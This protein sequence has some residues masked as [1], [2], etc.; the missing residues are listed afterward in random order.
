AGPAGTSTVETIDLANMM[1]PAAVI[2]VPSDLPGAAPGVSPLKEP[3]LVLDHERRFG[4]LDSTTIALFRSSWDRLYLPGAAGNPYCYDALVTGR[5]DGW[6]APSVECMRLLL[7]R[8]VG[9]IGID[10][11]SMG[12]SHDGAPVH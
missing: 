5:G 6:P 8:G 10:S 11:P 2:D 4:K 7:D 1:G 12:P 3:E 9:C